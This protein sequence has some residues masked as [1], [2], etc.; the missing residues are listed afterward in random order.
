[1]KIILSL[2][3]ILVQFNV[4]F[5]SSY[6]EK[7]HWQ[8]VFCDKQTKCCYNTRQYILLTSGEDIVQS[9]C[10]IIKGKWKSFYSNKILTS[11]KQI[12]IDHILAFS[13]M[14]KHGVNK[15]DFEDQMFAYND[16]DNLTIAAKDENRKKSDHIEL[17][18]NVDSE[19]EKNYKDV[20]CHICLRYQLNSCDDLCSK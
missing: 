13:Y 17:P 10:K 5:A 19:I 9:G 18:F 15:L 2:L 8:K 16:L 20:Q 3:L 12:E 4:S 14:Y 11:P 6:R 7:F 1:M